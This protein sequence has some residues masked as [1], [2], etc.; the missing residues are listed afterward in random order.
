MLI[1]LCKNYLEENLI[2]EQFTK[3]YCNKMEQLNSVISGKT[4]IY[5]DMNYWNYMRDCMLGNE[6]DERHKKIFSL[7]LKGVES[8]A[9]LCPVSSIIY[10]ETLKQS[11]TA[12]G[13]KTVQALELLSQNVS[14]VYYDVLPGITFFLPFSKILGLDSPLSKC[15]IWTHPYFS[16]SSKEDIQNQLNPLVHLAIQ[17]ELIAPSYIDFFWDIPITKL[18]KEITNKRIDFPIFDFTPIFMANTQHKDD[19]RSYE[20]VLKKERE[21]CLKLYES[22]A[23]NAYV[24]LW[25]QRYPKGNENRIEAAYIEDSRKLLCDDYCPSFIDIHAKIHA[26]YRYENRSYKESNDMY[27]FWHAAYAVSGYD[28]FFTERKLAN[29]LKHRLVQLGESYDCIVESSPEKI[30]SLLESIV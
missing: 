17:P 19:F 6:T 29:V 25:R 20:E 27:D 24:S 5:L 26:L 4:K 13:S 23:K 8:G 30:I 11:G 7:L 10:F 3:L 22:E 16:L 1:C 28:C 15:P 21:G 12:K 18:F 9:I 2:Y 14:T